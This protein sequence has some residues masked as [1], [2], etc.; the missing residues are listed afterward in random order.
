MREAE[1]RPTELEAE[2]LVMW[3]ERLEAAPS[4]DDQLFAVGGDSLTALR[5]VAAAQRRYGV[6]LDRQRMFEDFTVAR[7]AALITEARD[8]R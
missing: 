7:M 2:L 8:Q 1:V 6:R 4:V 5:L 3:S